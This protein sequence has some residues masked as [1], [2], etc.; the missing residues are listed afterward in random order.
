[1]HPLSVLIL[2]RYQSTRQHD[3]GDRARRAVVRL[4]ETALEVG[5]HG[6]ARLGEHVGGDHDLSAEDRLPGRPRPRGQPAADR[7]GPPSEAR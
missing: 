5:G 4:V 7:E 6:D 2:A 3:Q 1:M